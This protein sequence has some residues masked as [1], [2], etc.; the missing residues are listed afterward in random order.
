M[1]VISVLPVAAAFLF[2]IFAIYTGL[3]GKKAAKNLWW[4][5]AVLSLLF[6][7]FTL[8]A[9]VNEGMFSFWPEHVR[10]LWGN[11]I[12]FD[13]LLAVGIG[14]FLIV[15]RATAAGMHILPWLIVVIC[16]GCIGFL[17]M[18]SRLLYLEENRAK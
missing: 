6:A 13:L 11:Q 3:K 4:F 5:P 1:A 8:M 7:V 12:W 16:S 2:L 17:A 15:P 14:W 9:V 18:L 10:N